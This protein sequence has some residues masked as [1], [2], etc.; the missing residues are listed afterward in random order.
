MQRSVVVVLHLVLLTLLLAGCTPFSEQTVQRTANDGTAFRF[1]PRQ[2]LSL[3]RYE[4]RLRG[5]VDNRTLDVLRQYGVTIQA[6]AAHY[7]MDWRL[8]LAVMKTESSFRASVESDKGAY[9]LM[10]I[11]PVTGAELARRL[12]LLDVRDPFNNIYGGAYYLH[13]LYNRFA[14]A[15]VSDR[16]K[17]TLAAYNAG[18]GRV[19]DAQELTLFFH[20]DPSRWNAVRQ[21]LTLLGADHCELHAVIWDDGRPRSGC[22]DN[23]GETLAYVDKVMDA[24][25]HYKEVL[26]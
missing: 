1:P 21:S 13:Q 26:E 14:G 8:I 3:T 25:S 10:Q 5:R 11:M 22:F 17:V 16:L 15:P 9:G 18:I 20:G 24:Y 23:P 4:Q 12:D 7:N 6:C 2:S 19:Y